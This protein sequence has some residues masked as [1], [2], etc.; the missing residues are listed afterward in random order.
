MGSY[1]EKGFVGS[2]ILGNSGKEHLW[3]DSDFKWPDFNSSLR[4]NSC[5]A[6][7]LP[8]FSCSKPCFRSCCLLAGF[9]RIWPDNR[10]GAGSKFFSPF[11]NRRATK[12]NL[13]ECSNFDQLRQVS[14]CLP[15]RQIFVFKP[16]RK[17]LDRR[18]ISGTKNT[19]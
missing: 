18:C 1:S 14:S 7:C 15:N 9:G 5:F 8:S 12:S 3:P 13:L 2:E 19:Q 16:L 6:L 10:F 17:F 4:A 11:V